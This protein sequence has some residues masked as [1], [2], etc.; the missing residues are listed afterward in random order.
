MG[1]RRQAVVDKVTDLGH[2]DHACALF[3]SDEE[4][5]ASILAWVSAGLERGDKLLCILDGWPQVEF[6]ATLEGAGLDVAPALSRGQIEIIGADQ[7]YL[8]DGVFDAD[9][10]IRELEQALD[11]ALAQGY[12]ALRVFGEMSW[13]LRCWTGVGQLVEYEASVA[14]LFEGQ[15]LL[16]LCLYDRRRFGSADQLDQLRAHPL[17]VLGP[18]VHASPYWLPKAAL[19]AEQREDWELT[20]WL[21]HMREQT[22]LVR[23]LCSSEQRYRQLFDSLVSGYALHEMIFDVDGQPV[24]YRF[25]DVNPAFEALTGLDAERVM[26]RRVLEVL[27]AL[28]PVWIERYGVVVRSGEPVRFRQYSSTL[29]RHYEVVAY[30]PEPGQFATVFSDITELIGA[31]ERRR[32]TERRLFESQK[33]DS[34]GLLAGGIA[35]D[36]NNMLMGV[37]GNASLALDDAPAGSA[38]EECL[39][40]IQLAAKNAAGLAKQLL[41]YS[42]RGRFV[43]EPVD[44]GSVLQE[45]AKLLEASI[46]KGVRIR[47]QLDSGVGPVHADVS[48]LRQVLMNLIL[49]AAQ[50]IGD[51]SGIITVAISAMDCDQEYLDTTFASDDLVAGRFVYLEITDTGEGMDAETLPR[52][53]DPFFSTKAAGRGLGLAATMGIVRGHK[54][55]IKVYSEVGRGSTFKVLLPEHGEPVVRREA[56]P[57]DLGDFEAQGIVLV[58][59]DEEHVRRVASRVL[60][61]MG[62]EVLTAEDGREA[63]AIFRSHQDEIALVLLDMMMPRMGGERTFTELR[64]IDASVRVLLTSGYNE[65]DAVARFVGRGLAGFIQKPYPKGE[66]ER[67]VKE[68]LG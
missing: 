58:V 48:Q 24:D 33:L 52:I 1:E 10:M 2:G 23:S 26:G 65:Q 38:L 47:Y 35:H 37:L 64:R 49:N 7:T 28:E 41:A 44:L 50:A 18:E 53:F 9:R 4:R 14:D 27:P 57:A 21:G 31:E 59:D 61:R 55:A 39:Q 62:F 8:R 43:V 13:V 63:V 12:P 6:I 60:R 3:E 20:H 45:M 30:R 16:A 67:A 36:F 68:A 15:P 19:L 51:R 46:P 17:V 5:D 34:L 56:P 25:L 22:E 11:Q 40:D 29:E 66:L 42:G 32:E 54:G